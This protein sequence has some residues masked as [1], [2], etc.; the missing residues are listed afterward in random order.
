MAVTH[1]YLSVE[2]ASLV[3]AFAILASAGYVTIRTEESR[4]ESGASL[5]HTLQVETALHRLY[6]EI[7][8]AESDERGYL[9]TRD[10]SFADAS[11][12]ID[13]RFE[14]QLND[15]GALIA[16]NPEQVQRLSRLRPLLRDRLAQLD[17]KLKLMRAGRFDEAADMFRT[18]RGRALIKEIT[19][20]IV[21]MTGQEEELYRLR[22]ERQ[23]RATELLQ[24]AIGSM[25]VLLGG[26]AIF[27]VVLAHRQ[28]NALEKSRDSLRN[29]YNELIGKSTK[30]GALE[31]Q[32]RQ[33][34]KLE[35]LG[36]LAGGIAHDFNNMLGVIVAS[37]NIMRRSLAK[38]EAN[39]EQLIDS[40]LDGADRAANLV[41][42]LLAFS[43]IQPLSPTPLDA[44]KLVDG[45]SAILHRTLGARVQLVTSFGQDL[46][47]I[48][49]DANELESA[50]LNLAVNARDAM[51]LGG[52]LAIETANVE[53]D[54]REAEAN[55]EARPGQYVMIT[56]SDTGEGMAPEILAKAF[57]PFFTTK[58]VGKGTGLG[59]S[60]THGFVRQSGGHIKIHSQVGVGSRVKLYLP[61]FIENGAPAPEA[62]RAPAEFPRG[63]DGEVVLLVENDAAA[64]R[65]TAQ[66]V[67]ELGY[68]VIEA[69]SGADAIKTIRERSDVSL[70]I[71]DVFMRDLNGVRLARE[72]V[73][74][75]HALARAV[76]YRL[77][78]AR[79]H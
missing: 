26:V 15:L 21:D 25:M 8:A 72:A 48:R 53:L 79:G 36:Q 1:K 35:A 64:R 22:E 47:P 57:D 62:D 67:R 40:A 59:L 69:E 68:K 74:R 29:A 9:I 39:L 5:R 23:S 58:P 76:H 19:A 44:N 55:P 30:R 34:Q 51:P 17:Q 46:W 37:L 4:R 7:R 63:R 33:S 71:T 2:T 43:R 38:R 27:T 77:F 28:I 66:G 45:M 11:V 10:P 32:L 70:L 42:R 75:R 14:N 73:F 3:V 54:A 56:V 13:A 61:R 52:K 41:R 78:R 6:G 16:D 31:A 60:Q 18:G 50:I 24:R 49:V 65:I 20:L 12:G